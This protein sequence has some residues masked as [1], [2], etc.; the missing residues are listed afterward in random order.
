MKTFCI[1][2]VMFL[3]VVQIS[4]AQK[5]RKI[6][7]DE[8]VKLLN[9][10]SDKLH[11]VNFWATWCA[12]CVAELPGFQEVVNKTKNDKVDFLF[13]SLDFPSDGEQ[14]L[15]VFMKKNHYTFNVALMTETDSN[16]WIDR[17]DPAWQGEIP[18]T[19]FFNRARKIHQFHSGTLEKDKLKKTIQTLLTN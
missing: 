4:Q 16:S 15:S 19:L 7:K 13:V 14:K 17:V 9:D 3:V 5:I 18:S 12:P 11:V 8:L 6:S 2:A 10:P 1:S